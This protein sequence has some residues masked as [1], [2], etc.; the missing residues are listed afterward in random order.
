MNESALTR[1]RI[2]LVEPAG[3]LNVGSVARVMKNMGL[4]QL[5]L[6]KPHCDRLSDEAK[7]MAVHGIDVLEKSQVVHTIPEALQGCH[8]IIATTGRSLSLPTHLETP[9]EALPWLLTENFNTAL[10]FGPEDRGLNN[11]E[12]NYAQR[13]VCIPANSDYS[14]LNLAQAVAVCSYELHQAAQNPIESKLDPSFEPASFEALEGYYQHLEAVLLKIGYLYP[15]TAKARLE[16]F[17]RLYNKANLTNEEVA[18]LR[19]ILR[20]V[21]WVCQFIPP[22]K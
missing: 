3:P 13:F 10:L 14:S 17:R 5:I 8:R 4:N 22:K 15:H 16:K 6:V 20:Q 18:L 21:D 2:V 9:R 1:V 12:L 11:E 7:L 19:G